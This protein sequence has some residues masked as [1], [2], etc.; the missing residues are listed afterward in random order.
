MPLPSL[1]WRNDLDELPVKIK[2]AG[3][4]GESARTKV[5]EI[6][7]DGFGQWLHFFSKTTER[8]SRAFAHMFVLDAFFIAVIDGEIVGIAACT[9]GKTPSVRLNSKEL[10]RHLGLVRG[11]IAGVVLKKEFENHRYPF[12]LE[13]GTGLIEFVATGRK[14]R[15]KGVASSL[16]QHILSD[17]PYRSYVLEVVDTNTPAISLYPR[18][19]FKEFFRIP[20]K[21]SKLSG[22]N[23]RVYMKYEKSSV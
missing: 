14:Y 8:L 21:H 2:P 22:V 7:A 6:F 11:S 10:R 1:Y 23:Y 5:S 19:G 20:Q 9:D 3:E 4:V 12:P 16:I 13:S 15:R 18:L 17:T